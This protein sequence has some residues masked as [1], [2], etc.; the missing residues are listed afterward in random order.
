M[1]LEEVSDVTRIKTL[2][3]SYFRR[4]KAQLQHFYV[5]KV[6]LVWQ[7][8]GC[9]HKMWPPICLHVYLPH[10]PVLASQCRTYTA[11]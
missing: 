2:L 5:F 9:L 1:E 3:H 6:Y 10:E 7:S 8:K 4:I 11:V